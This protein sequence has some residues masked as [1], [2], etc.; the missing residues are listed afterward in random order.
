MS[1]IAMV[2]CTVLMLSCIVIL[3]RQN[4][5]KLS[6]QRKLQAVLAKVNQFSNNKK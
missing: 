4:M 2:F 3:S 5:R 6:R 1:A